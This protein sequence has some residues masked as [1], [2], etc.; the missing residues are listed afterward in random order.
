MN[1][2]NISLFIKIIRSSWTRYFCVILFSMS[3]RIKW[4]ARIENKGPHLF[5]SSSIAASLVVKSF[6]DRYYCLCSPHTFPQARIYGANC[7]FD[8]TVRKRCAAS[9]VI[10][11]SAS[12]SCSSIIRRRGR[13]RTCVFR[14]RAIQLTFEDVCIYTR[15]SPR[16]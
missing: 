4:Q 6:K 16:N 15:R 3:T 9:L 1:N 11:D 14:E 5:T 13:R 8:K 2:I 10:I 7:K 12:G